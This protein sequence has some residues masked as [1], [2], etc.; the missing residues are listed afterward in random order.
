M[1][2]AVTTQGLL[3]FTAGC[4]VAFFLLAWWIDHRNDITIRRRKRDWED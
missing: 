4:Y 1:I 3:L 2:V